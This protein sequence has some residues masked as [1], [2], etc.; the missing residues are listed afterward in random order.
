MTPYGRGE[1]EA[2]SSA[3]ALLVLEQTTNGK[4]CDATSQRAFS[5][6]T[7]H[8]DC[9]RTGTHCT[10]AINHYFDDVWIGGQGAPR[11]RGTDD[12]TIT[13]SLRNNARYKG[14][15]LLAGSPT[16]E[17]Y[18]NAGRNEDLCTTTPVANAGG[19]Y[20]MTATSGSVRLTGTCLGTY[21]VVAL[22]SLTSGTTT[23]C[24][25][26]EPFDM[27]SQ[28]AGTLADP[29]ATIKGCSVPNQINVRLT[30]GGTATSNATLTVN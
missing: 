10:D 27:G 11:F 13:Q 5:S 23:G 3:I 22:W 28:T 20:S 4:F 29:Q 7:V 6:C 2:A 8:A 15:R 18:N 12:E 1:F 17:P 19:P 21:D 14:D 25:I 9:E 30:C 24:A 26:V 16:L